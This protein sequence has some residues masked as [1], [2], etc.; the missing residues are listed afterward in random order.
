M[1]PVAQNRDWVQ[2]ACNMSAQLGWGCAFELCRKRDWDFTLPL[3]YWW[4]DSHMEL[5][6]WCFKSKNHLLCWENG[7]GERSEP[8]LEWSNTAHAEMR[9][10]WALFSC[11]LLWT[12]PTWA[13]T[14]LSFVSKM[15]PGVLCCFDRD[16][17]YCWTAK[18]GHGQTLGLEETPKAAYVPLDFAFCAVRLPVWLSDKLTQLACGE[19][20]HGTGVTLQIVPF[21]QVSGQCHGW[22]ARII[23]SQD[24]C[25]TTPNE[26]EQTS[27]LCLSLCLFEP[28]AL[29][30]SLGE[31]A[32][33]S[34]EMAN[35][36]QTRSLSS[37]KRGGHLFS[38]NL[39]G[40]CLGRR[41]QWRMTA[42]QAAPLSVKRQKN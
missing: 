26:A 24:A 29:W 16:T 34:E 42:G 41:K 22:P 13:K 21:A 18:V 31:I 1:S 30:S 5:V 23:L 15:V 37:L 36:N 38:V 14:F 17:K 8:S 19:K 40:L 39:R 2:V 28:I 12:P 35:K 20:T 32:T 10:V 25:S 4:S 7:T 3:C 6:Y 33:Q 11:L 27:K 9:C